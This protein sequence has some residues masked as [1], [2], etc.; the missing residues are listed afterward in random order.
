MTDFFEPFAKHGPEVA[1]KHEVAQG[2]NLANAASKTP[3][4]EHYIWSTLPNGKE[5]TK[6]KYVV[7]HFEGKNQIDA[8]IKKDFNLLSKTTF[9]WNSFY[10][11]NLMYPPFT[12]NLL[13][14]AIATCSYQNPT[15]D[16]I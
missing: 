16:L 5:L 10:A 15:T 8:Y 3:S 14:S 1:L 12:P 7:P 13:V 6:G 2:I 9:L 11:S 4:L